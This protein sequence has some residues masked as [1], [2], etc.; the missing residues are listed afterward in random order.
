MAF[1]KF[2]L[3]G[4]AI[5]LVAVTAKT[6]AMLTA[7]TNQC[8]RINEVRVTFDGATSTAVP[9]LIEYGRPSS[10]G[11]F[12][13]QTPKKRDPGRAETIQTTG[14]VNSSSEPTWTSVVDGAFYEPAYGGMYHY[15]HPFN[16]EYIVPGGGRFGIR[17]TAP[18]N[19]NSTTTIAGE[20]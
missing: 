10:A 13:S 17:I 18:A 12:T 8:V 2:E 6:V 3:T 14:G 4:Q 1:L 9:P 5:A 16:N 7:A 11:T 19:V 15:I 20:E